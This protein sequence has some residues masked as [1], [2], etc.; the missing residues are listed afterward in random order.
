[1]GSITEAIN[2]DHQ[3]LKL[4][5]DL[6]LYSKD[7]EEQTGFQNQLSWELA[8]HVVGEELVLYPALESRCNDRDREWNDIHNCLQHQKASESPS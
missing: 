2:D 4:I 7:A 8:R 1:M 3:E 5:Y 6:I